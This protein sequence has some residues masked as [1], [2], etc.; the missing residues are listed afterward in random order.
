VW[1]DVD[2]DDLEA[3]AVVATS[4]AARPAKEVEQPRLHDASP[5]SSS[6]HAPHVGS[7]VW[8]QSTISVAAQTRRWHSWQTKQCSQL[9][10]PGAT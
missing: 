6:Q 2:A 3:G 1:L 9:A 8:A 5:C 7:S 4:G 10:R